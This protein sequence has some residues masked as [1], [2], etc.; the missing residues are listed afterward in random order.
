MFILSAVRL[1]CTRAD[2]MRVG[3]YKI[4]LENMSAT[5]RTI[6]KLPLALC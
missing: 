5:V 4:E 6:D 1:L 2:E 3:H